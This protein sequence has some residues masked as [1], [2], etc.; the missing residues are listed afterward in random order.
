[1]GTIDKPLIEDACEP[2]ASTWGSQFVLIKRGKCTFVTKVRNA[3]LA[4]Y[5]LAIIGDN[6]V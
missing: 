6:E 5:K 3:E 2:I 1:M 4:G